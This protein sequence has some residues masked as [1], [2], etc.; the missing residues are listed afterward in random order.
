MLTT[1]LLIFLLLVL[2]GGAGSYAAPRYG[3]GAPHWGGLGFVLLVIVLLL[4]FVGPWP[5]RTW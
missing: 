2:F 4:L 5:A 1:L 3:W